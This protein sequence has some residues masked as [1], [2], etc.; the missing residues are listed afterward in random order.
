[1]AAVLKVGLGDHVHCA[2]F[3]KKSKTV[4]AV[5]EMEKDLGPAFQGLLPVVNAAI[6]EGYRIVMA[7]QCDYLKRHF[8]HLTLE[9]N[10][11]LLSLVIARKQDGESFEGL[12]PAPTQGAIPMYESA[13]GSYQVAAFDAGNFF[14]YVVSDLNGRTNLQ[15]ASVL[16]PGV[17]DLLMK[18]PA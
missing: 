11:S 6:P 7:H 8:V 12:A 3:R 13:A 15:I 16:A 4:P 9:N 17:R 1:M 5:A 18:A 2:V 10:G 14:A